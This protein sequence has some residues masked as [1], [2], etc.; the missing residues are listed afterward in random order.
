MS[1]EI[2]TGTYMRPYQEF[3]GSGK[4]GHHLFSVIRGAGSLIFRD[5][6]SNQITLERFQQQGFEMQYLR[7]LR[8]RSCFFQGAGS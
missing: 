4:K 6:G 7:Y 3:W 2:K 8:E 5:M 1:Y